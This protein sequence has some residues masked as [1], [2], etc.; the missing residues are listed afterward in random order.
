[1]T[2]WLDAALADEGVWLEYQMQASGPD[3]PLNFHPAANR[4][5]AVFPPPLTVS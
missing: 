2:F 3:L 1:M 4:A 5:S